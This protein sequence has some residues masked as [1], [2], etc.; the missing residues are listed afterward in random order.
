M[1]KSIVQELIEKVKNDWN[2]R[3]GFNELIEMEFVEEDIDYLLK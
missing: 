3:S 2:L 1:T